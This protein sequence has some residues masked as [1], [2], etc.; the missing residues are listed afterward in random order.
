M[1]DALLDDTACIWLSSFVDNFRQKPRRVIAVGGSAGL[2]AELASQGYPLIYVDKDPAHL[3]YMATSLAAI[4]DTNDPE[5][6]YLQFDVERWEGQ[7]DLKLSG[8]D[9]VIFCRSLHHMLDPVRAVTNMLER[10][11]QG[12]VLMADMTTELSAAITAHDQ[13]ERRYERAFLISEGKEED[14]KE[15]EQDW[16]RCDALNGECHKALLELKFREEADI[17]QFMSAAATSNPSILHY[18]LPCPCGSFG[19]GKVVWYWFG[20]IEKVPPNV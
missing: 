8:Q 6:T 7:G 4:R 20:I 2:I 5:V 18:T 10:L 17:Q 13:E 3:A 16:E 14:L 1:Q 12:T 11:D 15:L 9:C 19:C